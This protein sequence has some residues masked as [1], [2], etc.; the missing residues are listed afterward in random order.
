LLGSFSVTAPWVSDHDSRRV[1][2]YADVS[3]GRK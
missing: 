1:S 2:H 3:S